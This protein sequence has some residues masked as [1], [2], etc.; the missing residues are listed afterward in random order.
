MG[1]ALAT[2]ARDR[3]RALSRRSRNAAAKVRRRLLASI[4]RGLL[5]RHMTDEE[6]FTFDLE[7]F[8]ILK[9]VLSP[10]QVAR[11][12]TVAAGHA[13]ADRPAYDRV[14]G[15]STWSA[16]Y[17]AL[18]DHPR[19]LPYLLD[20]LGPKFRLDHDY[21]IFMRRGGRGQDLHG[22]A[23]P[24]NPD[25][26][27]Q[28]RDGVV[29]SGLT[30]VGFV[31]TPA[32]PGDGGFCCIPGSHKSNFVAS[33][34]QA[35]RSYARTPPYVVQAAVE[36]GDAIIFTEALIHGTAPWTAEHE[37]MMVIYKYSAGHS[38]WMGTYPDLTAY[39]DLTEQQRRILAP[40]SIGERPDSV[41]W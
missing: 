9:G 7:G 41:G 16:D 31:L 23:T 18:I 35:V 40:P 1:D 32:R 36:P 28:Y 19:I 38:A 21:C 2:R 8:L 12:A 14:F 20:L 22:G 15:A 34:P 4:A 30:V 6:L 3:L 5:M 11:L 39:R 26:W 10:D 33:L 27:Y 25:H 13:A 29:R 17:Q 24:D 37:R